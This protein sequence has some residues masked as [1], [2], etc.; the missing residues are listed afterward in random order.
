[1]L[2]VN[3]NARIA[4]NRPEICKALTFLLSIDVLASAG[5]WHSLL[6]SG[7]M[8]A[9]CSHF[10]ARKAAVQLIIADVSSERQIMPASAKGDCAQK[11]PL[12]SKQDL[13]SL[14]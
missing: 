2:M 8:D 5:Y 9:I 1:M 10:C 7:H 14:G 13:V 3:S 11:L 12:L 4:G 6:L